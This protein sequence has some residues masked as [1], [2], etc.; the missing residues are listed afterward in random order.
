MK[1]KIA[2]LLFLIWPLMSIIGILSVIVIPLYLFFI[3]LSMAIFLF[4]VAQSQTNIIWRCTLAFLFFSIGGISAHLNNNNIQQ[5]SQTASYNYQHIQLRQLEPISPTRNRLIFKTDNNSFIQITSS[6]PPPLICSLYNIRV[7][8]NKPLKAQTPEGFNLSRYAKNKHIIGYGWA[9]QAPQATGLV[10]PDL[11]CRVNQLRQKIYRHLQQYFADTHLNLAATLLLGYRGALG[12]DIKSRFQYLGISHIL[13][14]SGLHVGLVALFFFGFFRFILSLIPKVNLHHNVKSIAAL[15]TI[16]IVIFYCIIAGAEAS[17]LRAT[18]MMVYGLCAIILL[19]PALSFRVYSFALLTIILL[20]PMQIYSSGFQLSF[21][22]V[23]GLILFSKVIWVK[24]RFYQ[25][26]L[27]TIFII[28]WLMPIS[29]YY[30]GFVSVLSVIA[31]I[32]V[33]PF[34]SFIILPSLF[35]GF[36]F[37]PIWKI[38][39]IAI[40]LL[41]NI[42]QK[43]DLSIMI[44]TTVKPNVSIL[45]ITYLFLTAAFIIIFSFSH[46]IKYKLSLSVLFLANIIFFSHLYYKTR[47]INQDMLVYEGPIWVWKQQKNIYIQSLNKDIHPTPYLIK[48]LHQYYGIPIHIKPTYLYHN[49]ILLKQTHI[50]YTPYITDIPAFCKVYTFVFAPYNERCLNTNGLY[51]KQPFKHNYY[52]IR[53]IFDKDKLTIEHFAP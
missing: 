18:I 4:F 10:Q 15:L 17:T 35:L 32:L 39:D 6:Y 16:P 33:I 5:I 46:K 34:L 13:A 26:I 9:L 21:L 7:F 30:F 19:R 51:L 48:Q 8:L 14:I 47:Q 31:N 23:F 50:A 43:H 44:I 42:T 28:L 52:R 22:A 2:D 20:W 49:T 37:S 45:I 29:L 12:D 36:L 38:S 27:T 53:H 41:L 3:F 24:N 11:A 40:G 1:N 25:S